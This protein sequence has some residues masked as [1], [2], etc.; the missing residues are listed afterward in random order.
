MK[1]ADDDADADDG[2]DVEQY[3][4][5]RLGAIDC[6]DDGSLLPSRVPADDCNVGGDAVAAEANMNPV[7]A[8][9]SS[10]S[11]NV[12]RLRIRSAIGDD[13]CW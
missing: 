5:A 12:L 1:L 13:A 11:A 4:A 9:F 2:N 6:V 8:Q 7:V 10:E 3:D